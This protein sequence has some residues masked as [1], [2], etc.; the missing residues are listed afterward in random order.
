MNIE[1]IFFDVGGV[2]TDESKFTE[3]IQEHATE[4]IRKYD[5]SITL[6]KVKEARPI[7]SAMV[8]N[9]NENML[10]VFLKG[11]KLETAL[12]EWKIIRKSG[13][14]HV[15]LQ[16]VHPEALE[17]V[18]TLSKKYKLGLIANQHKEIKQK[19]ETAGI[20]QYFTH[21][22][23]SENYGV[24]KPDPRFFEMAMN[25]VGIEPK[26]A[27]IVD[28]NLERSIVPAKKIGMTTIWLNSEKRSVTKVSADYIITSLPDLIE[29][30]AT[31]HN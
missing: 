23:V 26:D 19:L 10:K 31:S 8:G 22:E 30:L 21:A 11:E 18:K 2:L 4:V 14:T 16:S 3:W 7:A 25:E 15:E 6:E 29:I 27:A 5:P 24:E 20:L 17:V 13:P 1:W 12:E 28:D 9:L